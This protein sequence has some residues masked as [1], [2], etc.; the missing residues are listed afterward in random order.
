MQ[1]SWLL[2]SSCLCF[3]KYWATS[4]GLCWSRK[5]IGQ[6]A[7]EPD[8]ATEAVAEA[9][10]LLLHISARIGS[11][12]EGRLD[13]RPRALNRDVEL[14]GVA[15]GLPLPLPDAKGQASLLGVPATVKSFSMGDVA[16]LVCISGNEADLS[17][18]GPLHIFT[19]LVFSWAC[20]LTAASS[21]FWMTSAR[22]LR[23]TS[24]LCANCSTKFT[25]VRG[26]SSPTRS[27]SC[28]K[29][30]WSCDNVVGEKRFKRSRY[31]ILSA[32]YVK[33]IVC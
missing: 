21:A 1:T 9:A 16:L 6:T 24:S 18:D 2:G 26:C 25:C 10:G 15:S 3:S 19:L 30:R 7:A 8:A 12:K 22:L 33:D 28:R 14:R 13:L 27:R 17:A 29:V 5:R 11:V 20:S 32:V 31:W 4:S 23:S